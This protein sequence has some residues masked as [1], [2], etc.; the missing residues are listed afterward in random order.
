MCC[1][2]TDVTERRTIG[3]AAGEILLPPIKGQ[4]L[5]KGNVKFG[6]RRI[7]LK[8]VLARRTA[9]NLVSGQF[10]DEQFNSDII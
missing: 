10:D 6:S 9:C 2:S 4:N 1:C 8:R 7:V 5:G 3:S